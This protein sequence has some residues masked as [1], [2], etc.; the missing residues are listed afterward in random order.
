MGEWFRFGVAD[1]TVAL[2]NDT[3]LGGQT[4]CLNVGFS[5]NGDISS[6]G[7]GSLLTA[8]LS[9]RKIQKGTRL[10]IKWHSKDRKFFF[11]INDQLFGSFQITLETSISELFP[12]LQLS[13]GTKVVL[14]YSS[15]PVIYDTLELGKSC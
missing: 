8:D 2:S 12:T 5:E 3:L 11:L 4:H 7:E 10:G 9:L 14:V 15:P 1:K 6:S 13:Y